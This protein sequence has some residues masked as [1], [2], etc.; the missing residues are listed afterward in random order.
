M[1]NPRNDAAELFAQGLINAEEY[2]A[3]D[4]ERIKAQ[5]AAA[6]GLAFHGYNKHSVRD[7]CST[8]NRSIYGEMNG[9]YKEKF[10]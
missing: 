5:N 6:R 10:T 7:Q 4:Q 9:E 3:R 8:D 2:Y 1:S